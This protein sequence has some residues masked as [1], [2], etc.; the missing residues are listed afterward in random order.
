MVLMALGVLAFSA[1]VL[2]YR[3]GQI[4]SDTEIIDRYA[5]GYLRIAGGEAKVTD[6]QARPHPDEGV[7][8][9]IT[10]AA[11]DGSNAIFYVGPRGRSVAPPEG[12]DA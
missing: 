10:C 8:M 4:P 5:A 12:P 6:C 11:P 7:R 2:G 9:V 3:A 1:A